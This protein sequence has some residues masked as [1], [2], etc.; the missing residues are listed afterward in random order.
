MHT[1]DSR[2]K[3][4]HRLALLC[5]LL[6]VAV[7]SLSALMRHRAAGLGCDPWPACYGQGDR[8]AA[9]P[10]AVMVGGQA[11][12]AAR[13]AHRIAATLALLLVIA[14][15]AIAFGARPALRR[16]G[17]LAL[18]LLVLATLL[19]LLGLFTP[20]A[21][22]PAVAM[23]NLLGGML[24]LALA[25]RLV[26]PPAREGLGLAAVGVAGLLLL[27]TLSGALVS[28]SHAG[29][30][31]TDIAECVTQVRAAGWDWPSLDPWREPRFA[32]GT[33]HPDGALAQLLH[34]LGS[35]VVVPAVAVLGVAAVRRGRRHAGI[36]LLALLALQWALGMAIGSTG[37]PLVPVLLHNLGTALLLALV[38]RL[39]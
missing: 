32:V 10:G 17:G 21:R 18:A 23:A 20:G 11:L 25:A 2:L 15:V 36:A 33:P 4:L 12:T 24:M 16:A 34:R 27:Q 6:L 29:L 39:V 38:L 26:G 8:V 31:C 35:S 37:L 9:T 1:T 13:V 22:L 5:L 14:M 30:A 3:L 19:A 7:T 28:A